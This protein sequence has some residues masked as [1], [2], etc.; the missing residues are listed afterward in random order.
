MSSVEASL[1][2]LSA[3]APTLEEF[4]R[5]ID[6]LVIAI[7]DSGMLAEEDLTHRFTDGMYIRELHCPAGLLGVSMLHKTQHP[8][9]IT[10]GRIRVFTPEGGTVE[11]KA[12]DFGITEPGTRRV[13]FALEDTTWITF[14]PCENGETVE[15]I[16]ARAF[17]D[18][19][20]PNGNTARV[21]WKARVAKQLEAG[22]VGTHHGSGN[23]GSRDSLRFKQGFLCVKKSV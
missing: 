5:K 18:M 11:L 8:Y 2:L 9:V 13:G 3:G 1:E 15:Q 6:A 17:E 16:E 23:R 21:E 4:N 20:L 22:D 19:E 12:G 14:H 7:L 10:K